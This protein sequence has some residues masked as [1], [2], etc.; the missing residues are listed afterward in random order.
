MG[1]GVGVGVGGV[2]GVRRVACGCRG[3]DSGGGG[4]ALGVE[5]AMG[6]EDAVF[7]IAAHAGGVEGE[8]ER[9]DGGGGGAFG[10]EVAG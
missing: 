8:G 7:V 9:D 6:E 3:G 2:G 10:D 4:E 1:E 5:V